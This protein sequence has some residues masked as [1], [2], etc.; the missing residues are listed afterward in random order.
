MYDWTNILEN[1]VTAICS[2]AG[3]DDRIE[4]PKVK[5]TGDSDATS[6]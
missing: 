1:A 2:A 3:T 5:E 6:K 4:T